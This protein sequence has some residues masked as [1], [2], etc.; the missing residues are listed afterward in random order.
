MVVGDWEVERQ[1]PGSSNMEVGNGMGKTDQCEDNGK[2]GNNDQNQQKKY[3]LRSRKVNDIVGNSKS[4]DVDFKRIEIDES[5]A[6]DVQENKDYIE[7]VQG[8]K[9]CISG[10]PTNMFSFSGGQPSRFHKSQHQM[11]QM[12]DT[13][14][15]YNQFLLGQHLIHQQAYSGVTPVQ[16]TSPILIHT[17]GNT[18]TDEKCSINQLCNSVKYYVFIIFF[19]FISCDVI[20]DEKG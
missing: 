3:N 7:M 10:H 12:P 16:Y 13:R 17:T 19:L 2:L 1:T 9:N 5:N 6:N 11:H 15:Q 8:D 4:N 14:M 20:A 18:S